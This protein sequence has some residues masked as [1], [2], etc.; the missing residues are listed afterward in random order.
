[1]VKVLTRE[2]TPEVRA[3]FDYD[4]ARLVELAEHPNIVAVLR[5]GYT[6]TNQPVHR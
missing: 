6:P 2:A 3:R 4:Q 1:M 5:Y